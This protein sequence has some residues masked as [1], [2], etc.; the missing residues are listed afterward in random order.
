MGW[1]ELVSSDKRFVLGAIKDG[2]G[3]ALD[4]GGG[5]GELATALRSRGYHYVNVDIAASG[6]GAVIGDAVRLPFRDGAFD[7]IVS[8][9]TLE[10]FPEPAAALAEARRVLASEG[11]LVVRVPFLHPFH[12]DDLYRYTPLGLGYLLENA[13]FAVTSIEAPLSLTSLLAQALIVALRRIGLGA[14]DGPIE[15]GAARIDGFL[16]GGGRRGK[17][18]AASYLV[19][20]A[21]AP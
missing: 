21:V 12:G 19:R 4:L 17:G 10:H 1:R 16:T 2:S 6:P 3:H 20:A 11:A 7:L 5:R 15:Q 14:L 8:S 13:G 18:F 9:D